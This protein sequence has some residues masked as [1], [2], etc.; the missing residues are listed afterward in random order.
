MDDDGGSTWDFQFFFYHVVYL[1]G[2]VF[3]MK[4]ENEEK[5]GSWLFLG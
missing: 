1:E 3:L 5:N 4:N 2:G